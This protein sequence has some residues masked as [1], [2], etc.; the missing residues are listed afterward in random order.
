MS[1]LGNLALFI[2]HSTRQELLYKPAYRPSDLTGSRIEKHDFQP[3][4]WSEGIAEIGYDCWK[5]V[6]DHIAAI[7]RG[8]ETPS[9]GSDRAKSALQNSIC[10]QIGEFSLTD[11]LDQN[12]EA[13]ILSYT[14]FMSTKDFRRVNEKSETAYVRMREALGNKNI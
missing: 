10:S 8:R 4:R 2:C 1:R 14:P 7:S 11:F 6:Y 9:I 12:C 5:K 3:N 13:P